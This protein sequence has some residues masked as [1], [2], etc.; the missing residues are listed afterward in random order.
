MP[1]ESV[2]I[3]VQITLDELVDL[4]A[5]RVTGLN[6]FDGKV[7]PAPVPVSARPAGPA[8]AAAPATEISETWSAEQL[9][10]LDRVELKQLADSYGIRYTEKVRTETLVSNILEAQGEEVEPEEDELPEDEE[11]EEEED[12]DQEDE[13]EEDEPQD[14]EDQEEDDDDDYWTREEL[15]TKSL[16]ELKVIARDYDINTLPFRNDSA[17]L[18]DA[19]MRQGAS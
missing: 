6:G 17:R 4:V 15:E 14:Q 1:T 12:E 9:R 7:Q 11:D 16:G 5:A 3:Q 10:S 19:I 18:I 13:D 2:L 8:P